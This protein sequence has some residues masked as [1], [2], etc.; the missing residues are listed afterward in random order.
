[1]FILTVK[2]LFSNIKITLETRYPFVMVKGDIVN[3]NYDSR[4]NLYFLLKDN[5]HSISCVCW[6]GKFS[7]LTI[8][9]LNY[10]IENK[11]VII[12]GLINVYK[13]STKISIEVIDINIEQESVISLLLEEKKQKLINLGYFEQ[14]NK[15]DIPLWASIVGIITSKEGKV[16]YDITNTIK[17]RF[18]TKLLLYSTNVQGSDAANSIVKAIH[19]FNNL[20]KNSQPS[21]III[22]RGGG[23]FEDLLP[24]YEEILAEAIFKSSIPI[25]TAIGHS[26]DV[27]FADYAADKYAITPTAAAEM[28]TKIPLL[29]YK[30]NINL[31]KKEFN[32][33]LLNKINYYENKKK[34][35]ETKFLIYKPYL[36]TKL[37]K[38]IDL[39]N[40][41]KMLL[42][43]RYRSYYYK[44]N[45]IKNQLQNEASN[46]LKLLRFLYLSVIAK[47]PKFQFLLQNSYKKNSYYTTKILEHT[48]KG[49]LNKKA[50]LTYLNKK[51]Q[52]PIYYINN[53][54]HQLD[55]VIVTF[56]NQK[57]L[58]L[59]QK[60][61]IF[62]YLNNAFN[63]LS[64]KSTLKRGFTL[65]KNANS[66]KL[67]KNSGDLAK[68][69]TFKVVF[70]DKTITITQK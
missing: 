42:Q 69:K 24:F 14:S 51:L 30:Q 60:S 55:F 5:D 58:I 45:A 65:I 18:P 8:N 67:I 34:L 2:E 52:A 43:E 3:L 61:Q 62:N 70:L 68:E 28:V 17:E 38:V 37:S 15:K 39:N 16:I 50:S 36:S 33:S 11:E 6:K 29:N 46:K 25:I 54:I 13:S 64:Y 31:I 48:L 59:K 10:N 9:P 41:N 23:S 57:N 35:L 20:Q 12:K 49:L 56:Y 47:L 40:L 63:S 7:K 53:S 1:M 21:V 27:T 19:Y 44:L 66:E 26:T 32:N 22:A 4:G